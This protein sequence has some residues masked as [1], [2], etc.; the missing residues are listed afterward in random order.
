MFEEFGKRWHF[1]WDF[2][3]VCKVWKRDLGFAMSIRMEQLG[4][5]WMDFHEVQCL[6]NFLKISQENSSSIKS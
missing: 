1:V 6:W 2:G 3:Q 4:F 5:H